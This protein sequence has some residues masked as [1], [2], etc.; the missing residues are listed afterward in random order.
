MRC[1][2][3]RLRSAGFGGARRKRGWGLVGSL[4]D[5]DQRR[6]GDFVFWSAGTKHDAHLPEGGELLC[7]PQ[8][9]RLGAHVSELAG[10]GRCDLEG[11]EEVGQC[12]ALIHPPG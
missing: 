3:G 2:Q 12:L 9:I 1:A 10:G 11:L 6:V 7:H 8:P 4:L 5:T